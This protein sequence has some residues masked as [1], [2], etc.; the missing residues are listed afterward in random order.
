MGTPIVTFQ[1]TVHGATAMTFDAGVE[2]ASGPHVNICDPAA[3]GGTTVC[4]ARGDS[5]SSMFPE[6]FAID[7]V[8]GGMSPTRWLSSDSTSYH[9]FV[10]HLGSPHFV[11]RVR[12]WASR[13]ESELGNICRSTVQY[14]PFVS[15]S[16]RTLDQAVED[17]ETSIT[18]PVQWENYQATGGWETVFATDEQV[19]GEMNVEFD[20]VT[21]E[22]IR[23][24]MD[25][26]WGC[27]RWDS[28]GLFEVQVYGLP[29]RAYTTLAV[30]PPSR[31]RTISLPDESCTLLT[32]ASSIPGVFTTAVLAMVEL[33]DIV[34]L[35][36]GATV[37]RIERSTGGNDALFTWPPTPLEGQMLV[38]VNQDDNTITEAGVS[39]DQVA[40]VLSPNSKQL[41]F[42]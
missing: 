16:Y 17:M 41:F 22:V 5:G 34:E 42:Y 2:A 18:S 23:I 28:I 6:S 27:E 9:W 35:P 32:D 26:S 12:A 3:N 10:V 11:S 7:G 20:T 4:S 31:D 13:T 15:G 40:Q 29:E 8:V 19:N 33:P 38:V 36:D 25:M 24:N 14:L 39:D 37:V 21:T 1:S 30:E